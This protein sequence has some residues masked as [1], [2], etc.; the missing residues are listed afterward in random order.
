MP[1]IHLTTFIAAPI[2]RVFDLSRS[3]DVHKKS[4]IDF[5]ERPVNGKINGLV[6][7]NDTVTWCARHLG[8]ERRLTVK[9]TQYSKPFSFVDEQLSGDFKCMKHEH[10]FKACENGT[11]MID[12]F[13]FEAPYQVFGKCFSYLYLT[14]YMRKLLR[15]RNEFV[16]KLSE[17]KEWKHYVLPDHL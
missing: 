16:K 4:M 9:I 1:L 2:E 13:Y 12:K 6:D 5:K 10:F 8:K 17:T 3:I 15:K 11:I 14:G 7:L